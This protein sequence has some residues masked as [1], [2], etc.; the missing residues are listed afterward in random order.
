[1]GFLFGFDVWFV[2]LKI[3]VWY[4][5]SQ[6]L[7]SRMALCFFFLEKW[8]TW[9]CIKDVPVSTLFLNT[10]KAGGSFSFPRNHF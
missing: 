1:M 7:K 9:I 3:N 6:A 10:S 4:S 2:F 8:T 5:L